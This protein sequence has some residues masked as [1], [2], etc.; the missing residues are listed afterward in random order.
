MG[1][2]DWFKNRPAQFDPD[3]ISEEL[4]RGAVDKAITVT[5]PRLTV[6]PSCQ[7]RLAP[8]VESSIEF[9]RALSQ[10]K[11]LDR[12]DAIGAVKGESRGRL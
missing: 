11:L 8:A 9:L 2:L 4:I 12:L 6:L 3:R 5:N 7:K 1:I 10:E